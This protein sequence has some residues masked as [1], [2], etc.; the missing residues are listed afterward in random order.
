MYHDQTITAVI[1]GAGNSNRMGLN[2]NK[3]YI[4]TNNGTIVQHSLNAF[5]KH[6]YID[7]IVIV[8]RPEDQPILKKCLDAQPPAKP[9]RIVHG[10]ETRCDSVY[11]AI[12]SIESDISIIH[13]GARPF[14]RQKYITH[15]IEAMT[16]YYGSIIA[17]K[18]RETIIKRDEDG[19]ITQVPEQAELYLAQTPQC[20]HTKVL[21]QCHE[22]ADDKSCIT[23]D[24]S[25]LE[26]AGYPV[27]IIEGDATNIKITTP[28]DLI[29]A[30]SYL[31]LWVP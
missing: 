31:A 21:R 5:D 30:D 17:I 13:D 12:S 20:F 27:K 29:M 15:C 25:L 28:Q 1:L 8:A 3:V 10:G 7:D 22:T 19:F 16:D 11:N 6:P 26:L 18:N 14:L 24:S 2:I 4:S 9:V 23:D